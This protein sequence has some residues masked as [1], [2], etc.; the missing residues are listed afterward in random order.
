[1]KKRIAAFMCVLA[2]IAA[3][4]CVS[5]MIRASSRNQTQR[6]E[7]AI[8][9]ADYE[10]YG[11]VY[12]QQTNRLYY[13]NEL[14]RYFEDIVNEDSYRVW[15]NK[16]GTVDVYA[17]RY[18][19]GALAGVDV[20]D[21]QEFQ[22]RTPALE[23]AICELQITENIDGYTADTEELVK[24]ELEKA[25]AIYRQYGL[26][27]DRESDRLYYEGELVNYFED[28]ALKHFFGPFDDSPMDI[29]A[30]RDSQGTLTGLDIRN[31]DMSSEGGKKP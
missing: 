20:F 19:D 11:L 31:S 22:A 18:E 13:N 4:V 6:E 23:D 29:Q 8:L 12:N 24:D 1:M 21:E 26:T 7:Y 25:Y 15:P 16:D 28:E 9:F 3:A 27:Y 5:L 17:V 14:V 10:Q 30:I 2:L